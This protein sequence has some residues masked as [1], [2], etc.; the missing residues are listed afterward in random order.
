MCRQRRR[1][2]RRSTLLR[3]RRTATR[4]RSTVVQTR[5]AAARHRGASSATAATFDFG[6]ERLRRARAVP[7]HRRR[8]STTTARS[9]SR[10]TP[11]AR[12]WSW[13]PT[14]SRS[15]CSR[16]P[17]SSAPTSPSAARSASACRWASAA[18]TPR[19]SPR[20]DEYARQHARP[21]HRRLA[22]RA[23]ASP[24]CAWR[25]RPASST[26]AARRRRAT[27]APRRCCSASWPA[28]YAVYHGPEGLRRI[29][30]ARARPHRACSRDG[31]AQLGLQGRA[32]TPFFD[33]VARR[34][35][36][37]TRR[38]HRRPRRARDGSTCARIDDGRSASRSTRPPRP[39]TCATCSRCSAASAPTSL[40]ALAAAERELRRGARAHAARTSR[41]RSST[42]YHSETEML[43]YMRTLESRDLSLD[44][45]DDP[46]RLL[47]DEAQ[48]D[49]RDDPGDL[50]G[51]RPH[52][53]VR[54]RRADARLPA[55][56]SSE[57]EAWLAEITGFAAVSLQ[58]NAGSQG[59]YAGLLVIRALP[60]ERAA[61]PTATSASSRSRA[62]GTNPAQRRDGRLS[63]SSSSKC[64]DERQHR[65]RRPRRQGR[66]STPTSS[67]R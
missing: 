12:W 27:S 40:D 17:A 28:M 14:C 34:R 3:R 38:A 32:T 23:R 57:L 52:P 33:T 50:A 45:L 67:P 18:R 43:R 56:C 35:R 22:G 30:A 19:S 47:H 10:R 9:S 4:R 16:R 54:A 24:R 64:D 7:G 29:A 39:R 66:A 21:D 37:P 42:R 20:K 53:P 59:E 15:R 62:H 41:T 60:R 11:P 49:R 6:D 46:A 2:A 58:P 63:R 55:S 25:S 65:R 48:R 26:S 13:P 8:R 5:A 36:Q 61:R 51:V 31:L 1:R 44:A